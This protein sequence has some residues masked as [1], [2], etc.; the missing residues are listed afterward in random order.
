M[1]IYDWYLGLPTL[2]GRSKKVIIRGVKKKLKKA[3][4]KANGQSLPTYAM[5][6]WSSDFHLVNDS[7]LALISCF[8]VIVWSF[9]NVS[10]NKVTHG[11]A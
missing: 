10:G 9:V 1:D 3:H 2:V 7:D 4:G 11:L 8:D 5:S 6:V